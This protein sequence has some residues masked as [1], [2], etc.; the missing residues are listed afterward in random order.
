MKLL[1]VVFMKTYIIVQNL[2]KNILLL[3]RTTNHN[4]HQ[5]TNA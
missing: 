1:L 4:Y 3:Y 5:F 2:I